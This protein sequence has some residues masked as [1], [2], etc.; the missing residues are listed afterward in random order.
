MA[1]IDECSHRLD[2]ECARPAGSPRSRD[3]GVTSVLV[4]PPPAVTCRCSPHLMECD[5][6]SAF[7]ESKLLAAAE[8]AAEGESGPGP[9]PGPPPLSLLAGASEPNSSRNS[10]RAAGDPPAVTAGDS[11]RQECGSPAA[12]LAGRRRSKG[13]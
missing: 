10:S 8:A 9:G 6:K 7:I 12:Q 2:A 4:A 1:L 13:G 5:M 3:G 11:A